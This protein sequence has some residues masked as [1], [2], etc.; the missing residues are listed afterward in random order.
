[1][2]PKLLFDVDSIDPERVEFPVEAIREMN[3]QRYEFEQLTAVIC[4]R[5]GEKIAVGL[6]EIRAD[7][8]WVRGHIPGRPLFPGVLML[9]AA[10][11]LCSFYCGKVFGTNTAEGFYGFGGID[12]VRFRGTVNPGEKLLLLARPEILTP[13]RSVFDTQGVV[14]GKLVFEATIL[15]IRI[16]G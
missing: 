16:R 15:G 1:M 5:P 2:P 10:A 9:E 11:Q 4:F 6:R 13:N 7:E 14:S 8:Y 3:P 12:R